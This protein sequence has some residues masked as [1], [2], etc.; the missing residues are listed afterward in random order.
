MSTFLAVDVETANSDISSICQIGAV[1]F[2]D[3]EPV[4]EYATL[5]N[6]ETHFDG[7]NIEIHGIEPEMVNDAPLFPTAFGALTDWFRSHTVVSHGSFDRVAFNRACERYNQVFEVAG[8]LDSMKV[9]R[10]TWDQFAYKGYG[11]GK[12][13]AHFGIEFEH[14]D[15]LEDARAAGIILCRALDE[16]GLS[17]DDL[18]VRAS[19]PISGRTWA[20]TIK[21]DGN[22]D[23]PLFGEEI[24]FTGEL[25]IPRSEAAKLAAQAGCKVHP[26]VTK[27]TTMLVLGTQD[28]TKLAEGRKRSS[29]ER[30]AI[31]Y[32][33]KGFRIQFIN[34]DD[35]F[36]LMNDS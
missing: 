10:R 5:V 8:W 16:S 27:R 17:F 18:V 29:K 32:A 31:T 33:E 35:F 25:S 23:G 28:L 6:P 21:M 26:T 20:E 12:L 30:K 1:L 19:Q 36:L 15:A 7:L 3:G 22:P 24:V 11:L 9:V 14:H 13:C 4:E 34:E 2:R